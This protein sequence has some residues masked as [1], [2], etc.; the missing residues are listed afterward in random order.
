M[1]GCN[2]PGRIIRM[3]CNALR[4]ARHRRA[5]RA[6]ADLD[7]LSLLDVGARK[8]EVEDALSD[9]WRD[10]SRQLNVKCCRWRGLVVPDGCR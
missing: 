1:K 2:M 5:A 3:V 4:A 8:E 9:P 7:E 10:P 6:T